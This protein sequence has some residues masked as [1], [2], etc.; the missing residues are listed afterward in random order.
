MAVVTRARQFIDGLLSFLGLGFR[1]RDN[2]SA[3]QDF[4]PD[5]FGCAQCHG[6]EPVR[7]AELKRDQSLVSDSHFS[8][9]LLWCQA[10][11]QRFV[12]IF[13][14]FVDWNGGDDAQYWDLVPVTETEAAAL[15]VQGEDQDLALL[16][17]LGE[18]RRRLSSAWPTG[19]KKRIGWQTGAFMVLEG[20]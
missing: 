2:E 1:P 4:V 13:T 7:P 17:R 20:H 16:G 3:P 11:D 14:E 10:C 19:G 5:G 15:R 8:V 12:S 6:T 18:G 9:T